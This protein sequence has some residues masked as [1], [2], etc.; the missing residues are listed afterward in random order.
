MD[1]CFVSRVR[2]CKQAHPHSLGHPLVCV[3]VC[4]CVHVCP[5]SSYF[6]LFPS[7]SISFFFSR[8]LSLSHAATIIF[9]LP[10][11]KRFTVAANYAVFVFCLALAV[12]RSV[13][14]FLVA[15]GVLGT[16]SEVHVCLLSLSLS[17]SL[18]L[19]LTLFALEL[20]N[21]VVWNCVCSSVSHRSRALSFL[22]THTLSRTLELSNSLFLSPTH[23]IFLLLSLSLSL[24]TQG[25]TDYVLLE[26]PTFFYMS[27]VGVVAL[28]FAFFLLRKGGEREVGEHVFWIAFVVFNVYVW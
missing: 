20:W 5:S 19:A 7:L 9:F 15:A 11:K 25:S 24:C 23:C 17:L 2:F 4:M 6:S 21:L 14:F 27:A 28:S 18:A 1:R 26:L 3:C 10:I 16:S 22:H 13:Y 12:V 8:A